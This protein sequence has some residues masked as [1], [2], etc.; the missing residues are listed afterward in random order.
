MFHGHLPGKGRVVRRGKD[1]AGLLISNCLVIYWC[2]VHRQLFLNQMVQS[3][4]LGRGDD[5]AASDKR[6]ALEEKGD[7]FILVEGLRWSDDRL[8]SSPG[9]ACGGRPYIPSSVTSGRCSCASSGRTQRRRALTRCK[10]TPRAAGSSR[11]ARQL[12]EVP[13][14]KMRPRRGSAVGLS[15]RVRRTACGGRRRGRQFLQSAGDWR[16]WALLE[17]RFRDVGSLLE[18]SRPSF[19]WPPVRSKSR[20]L[21]LFLYHA[22]R[23]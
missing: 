5:R 12:P 18:E 20:I 10:G 6:E 19:L 7:H 2:G 8:I 23:R 22:M 14:S 17:G 3:P 4:T 16:P 1:R 15:F 11:L 9:W 13:S 21:L